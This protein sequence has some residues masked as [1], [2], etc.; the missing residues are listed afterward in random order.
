MA[1]MAYNSQVY[2]ILDAFKKVL[3]ID[4]IVQNH[5]IP[6]NMSIISDWFTN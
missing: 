4:T 2:P 5:K 1:E 6:S 3:K